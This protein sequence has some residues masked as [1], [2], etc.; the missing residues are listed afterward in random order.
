M[1]DYIASAANPLA[2]KIRLLAERKHRRKE[3]VFVVEGLQPVWC[4]V[5]AGWVIDVLVTAPE[6]ATGE[7]AQRL[8]GQHRDAGGRVAELTKE[9]FTRLM[10]RDHPAGV[11]ALVRTQTSTVGELPVS[12]GSLFLAVDQIANPG[13]LGTIMRTVD[14]V[15]G[16]GVILVGDCADPFSPAA[17]KASMGSV[18][19][20]PVAAT[21][22]E[23][24]FFEWAAS[25]NVAVTATSGQAEKTHWESSFSGASVVLMGS[26]RHGLS[27]SAMRAADTTVRIPM[28]GTVDS[29]NIGVAA[30][31]LLYE[32]RRATGLPQT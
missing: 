30:S 2:K 5:E 4:A 16:S 32:A 26:E 24:G 15:G 6:L 31:I 19:A 9:L 14:A 17:V 8:I 18:F 12:D 7:S 29:L 3:G 21:A 22:S 27:E 10:E 11:A 13:N 20:V 1:N 23:D 28:T 25:R